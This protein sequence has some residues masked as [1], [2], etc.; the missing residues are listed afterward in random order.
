MNIL[1]VGG[2]KGI[3][4][5]TCRELSSGDHRLFVADRDAG[6][7]AELSRDLAGG[8]ETLAMDIADR[9]SVNAALRWV[10]ENV[11][12]LDAAVIS[13]GVHHTYPIEFVPDELVDRIL[14]INLNA[15]IKLVRDLIPRMK[16]G[17][18]IVGVSSVSAGIGIPMEGVY[19]ASKAGLE[20]IYESLSV[21]LSDREIKPVIVQPG[22]VNTGFNE[23]GNDY[24]PRGNAYVDGVYRQ[25]LKVTDSR[26]GIDPA[27]VAR[28]IAQA[29]R[30][31]RPRVRYIVGSN[32]LKAHWA[33]RLLGLQG[34]LK[35][36]TKV[37][38][39]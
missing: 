6:A 10:D 28:T 36:M 12:P 39:L 11:G 24:T 2:A 34:A 30:A 38:G 14:D 22:N 20:R 25:V 4:K 23:S 1:I 13:A 31:D 7:L 8:V 29:I 26:Y 15:H 27:V 5:A 18:K 21:E 9:P 16:S 35:I 32:A 17:G 37:L 33:N 3:G 19:A